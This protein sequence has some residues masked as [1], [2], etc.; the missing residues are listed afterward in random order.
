MDIH[1][2]SFI[3]FFQKVKDYENTVLIIEDQN[4]YKF[5]GFCVDPWRCS[6]SFFGNGENLLFTFKDKEDPIIYSWTGEGEQHMY[7]N[8]KSIGLGGSS[9]K[10]RFALFIENDLYR[11]SSTNT[12]SYDNQCLAF[13]N[14]FLILHLEVWALID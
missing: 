12:E 9:T 7:A 11:G 3:T 2:C 5:G 1:G 13:S 8:N 4:G 10:G 6:Y 14:D